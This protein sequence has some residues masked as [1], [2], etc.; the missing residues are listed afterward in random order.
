MIFKA[1]ESKAIYIYIGLI[2]VLCNKYNIYEIYIFTLWRAMA[3]PLPRRSLGLSR[4]EA[5]A[6]L[7]LGLSPIVCLG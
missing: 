3:P 4:L 1:S 6:L 5:C 2:I 7:A